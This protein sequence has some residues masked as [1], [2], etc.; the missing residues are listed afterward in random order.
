MF[1]ET[2]G[3]FRS[4][5]AISELHMYTLFAAHMYKLSGWTS[6]GRRVKKFAVPGKIKAVCVETMRA[7]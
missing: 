4:S 1:R 2:F 5:K 6:G 7:A 3:H